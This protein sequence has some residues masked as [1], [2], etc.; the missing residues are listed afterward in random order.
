MVLYLKLIMQGKLLSMASFTH[1][2]TP[3]SSPSGGLVSFVALSFFFETLLKFKDLSLVWVF[4]SV[5]ISQGCA[6]CS[7]LSILVSE[8]GLVTELTAL[9]LSCTSWPASPEDP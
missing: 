6:L 8:T 7:S 1:H 9:H 3:L 5:P 2:Q 4:P